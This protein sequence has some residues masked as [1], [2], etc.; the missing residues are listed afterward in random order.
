[1]LMIF[2]GVGGATAGPVDDKRKT[3]A[4]LFKPPLDLMFQ[5]DFSEVGVV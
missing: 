2:I 3:L 4:K 5:G 1:M